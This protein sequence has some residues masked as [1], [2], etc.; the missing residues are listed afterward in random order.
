[1]SLLHERGVVVTGA[2][3]DDKPL[4][5]MT[6]ALGRFAA[7]HVL[8]AIPR[9]QESYWIERELLTKARPLA[10]V[11]VSQVVVPAAPPAESGASNV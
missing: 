10:A 2:V 5:S 7:T 1:L 3:G 4:Q 8:L 11:E 9:E 6:V